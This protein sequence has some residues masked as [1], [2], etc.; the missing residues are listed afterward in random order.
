MLFNLAELTPYIEGTL[1]CPD[2]T[3]D[4]LGVQNWQYNDTFTKIMIM[5]NI[6]PSEWSHQGGTGPW[7]P[8]IGVDS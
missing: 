3:I 5:N 7:I 4:P 8:D 1:P 2:P 6:A